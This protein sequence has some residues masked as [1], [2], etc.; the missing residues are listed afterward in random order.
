MIENDNLYIA[1]KSAS[2]SQ[3]IVILAA[4]TGVTNFI[5]TFALQQASIA[6]ILE[7]LS[8]LKT[9]KKFEKFNGKINFLWKGYDISI[10]ICLVGFC[11][12]PLLLIQYCHRQNKIKDLQEICG[13]MITAWMPFDLNH[14]PVKQI[15]YGCQVY[16]AIFI[17]KAAAT[18][19]FVF[20]GIMEHASYR[21]QQVQDLIKQ[22]INEKKINKK[23]KMFSKAVAYHAHF[24]KLVLTE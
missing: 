23:K 21:M 4:A 12:S 16:A 19:S 7:K 1:V 15:F 5:A 14:F 24:L 10:N 13:L 18:E 6:K 11:F 17:L 2:F 20:T 8:E 22:A 9:S 3:D